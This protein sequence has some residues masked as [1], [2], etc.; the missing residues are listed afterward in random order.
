MGAEAALAFNVGSMVTRPEAYRHAM[1]V[2]ADVLESLDFRIRLVDIGGGFP[3]SYPGFVTPALEAYFRTVE[4]MSRRLPLAEDGEILAEPGRALAAPG[5]SAVVEVLLRKDGRL[6][7]NDGMYGVFWELRFKAHDRYPVRAYRDGEPLSG[8]ESLFELYGPTCDGSDVLPGTVVLPDCIR[9]GDH[10]E[11]GRI[12]AYSVS[13]RTRFNGH[14]S[15][16][17]VEIIS[18]SEAPPQN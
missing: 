4:D 12:G 8:P 5:L 6:Y 11:F 7:L 18:P 10:L 15:D 16:R 1:G 13:G 3:R 2:A 14:Y 17:I 9:P